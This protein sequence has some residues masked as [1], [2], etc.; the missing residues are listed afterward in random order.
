MVYDNDFQCKKL[1]DANYPARWQPV[2]PSD[3]GAAAWIPS[4]DGTRFVYA[5]A[6]Q[7]RS[8]GLLS[9]QHFLPMAEDW[10]ASKNSVIEGVA[11]RLITDTVPYNVPSGSPLQRSFYCQKP[12]SEPAESAEDWAGVRPLMSADN[13]GLHWVRDLV[14]E[15]TL[16]VR[17]NYPG[18]KFSVGLVRAGKIFWCNVYFDSGTIE[19]TIPA[20]PDFGDVKL[21]YEYDQEH[22][23]KEYVCKA[24]TIMKGVDLYQFRIANV[25]DQIV[26]WVNGRTVQFD[27]PTTYRD[28][29]EDKPTEEDLTPVQ[30]GCFACNVEL[31]HLKLFRDI[32]YIAMDSRPRD[33]PCDYKLGFQALTT[34]ENSSAF[35]HDPGRA[36][37]DFYKSP[38]RW[39]DFP[40]R[41]EVEFTLHD[42]QF[43]MMGDNSSNSTDC[44]CWDAEHY[45]DESLLVGRAFYVVWPHA[46]RGFVPNFGK[47]RKIK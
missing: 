10:E 40:E 32:Y 14:F 23:E 42:G 46:K 25:D 9:Y 11:P 22:P 21:N 5:P 8:V 30:I 41:K 27:T 43:F 38:E 3:E 44:R 6:E 33:L 7:D 2:P 24:E 16:D 13:Y 45:V 17:A 12:Q 1:R 15:G 39:V 4:P 37:L 20:K 47:F 19:L 36:A 26:V 35:T 31:S 34:V 28:L 18:G 29:G